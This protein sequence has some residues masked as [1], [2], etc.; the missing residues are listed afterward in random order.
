MKAR[1]I[2]IH[3]VATDEAAYRSVVDAVRAA[4]NGE[5]ADVERG[6]AAFEAKYKLST[7]EM[8]ARV[9]SGTLAP[10]RD[11]ESW[12]TAVRVRDDLEQLKAHA[13]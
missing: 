12:L 1:A 8:R 4:P 2:R 10:T 13:K 5:I 3:R 11:I 9:Q 6:I 7:A